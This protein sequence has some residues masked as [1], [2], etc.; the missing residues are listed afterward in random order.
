M[1][2]AEL[3]EH[4]FTAI[5]LPNGDREIRGAYVGDLLSWVM[6]RCEEDQAWITIMSNVNVIAVA[7][8][9]NPSVVILSEGVT[10][11]EEIRNLAENKDVNLLSTSLP[12]YEAAVSLSAL[13]S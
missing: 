1:K 8:L 2:V 11:P 3:L 5:A 6:G 12:S 7:S 10:V 13:I 4:G 9:A